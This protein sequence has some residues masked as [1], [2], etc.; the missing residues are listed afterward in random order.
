MMDIVINPDGT[1]PDYSNEHVTTTQ[2]DIVLFNRQNNWTVCIILMIDY[3]KSPSL[4]RISI[5]F[6]FVPLVC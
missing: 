4:T 2:D 5:F 1:I 6:E 3:C